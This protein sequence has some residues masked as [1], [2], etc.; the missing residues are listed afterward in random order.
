METT[1]QENSEV[2]VVPALIKY[3]KHVWREK[4]DFETHNTVIL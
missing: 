4:L 3:L 2:K 1:V